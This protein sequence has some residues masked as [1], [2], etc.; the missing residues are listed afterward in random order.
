MGE[1]G[2]EKENDVEL[3]QNRDWEVTKTMNQLIST[4]KTWLKQ[5][6]LH[7]FEHAAHRETKWSD[8]GQWYEND[9]QLDEAKA[10]YIQLNEAKLHWTT[11]NQTA[12]GCGRSLA[13]W[14]L[15]GA[16]PQME[17]RSIGWKSNPSAKIGWKYQCMHPCPKCLNIGEGTEAYPVP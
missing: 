1:G 9:F 15:K 3:G 12:G 11:E 4:F 17:R 6:L 2:A 13:V 8:A 10:I 14:V 5:S 16:V 7:V